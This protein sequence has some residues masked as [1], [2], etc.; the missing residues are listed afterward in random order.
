M[1]TCDSH[2]IALIANHQIIYV[3]KTDI[4]GRDKISFTQ[5]ISMNQ[6]IS[7]QKISD[8]EN[9]AL[10]FEPHYNIYIYYFILSAVY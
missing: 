1:H 9:N 7:Q 4:L 3:L 6:V 2:Q 8:Y 5:Q 10:K